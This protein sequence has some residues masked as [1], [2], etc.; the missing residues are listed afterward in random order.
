MFGGAASNLSAE[1]S[2]QLSRVPFEP[3]FSAS[4]WLRDWLVFTHLT[5]IKCPNI[6]R[7]KSNNQHER[8][9]LFKVTVQ[10]GRAVPSKYQSNKSHINETG[11]DSFCRY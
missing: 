6:S 8:P 3:V 1:A 10:G 7:P 9:K 5:T 11:S 2:L 4:V